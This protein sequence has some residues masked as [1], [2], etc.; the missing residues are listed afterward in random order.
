MTQR[1]KGAPSNNWGGV[2]RIH[3]H[4]DE[5]ELFR[6]RLARLPVDYSHDGVIM[7]TIEYCT[8]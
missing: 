4:G 8:V 3:G 2:G 6:P 7:V 5:H 1:R